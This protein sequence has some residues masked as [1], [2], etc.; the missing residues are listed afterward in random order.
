MSCSAFQLQR[1]RPGDYVDEV[2]KERDDLLREV[3]YAK[4]ELGRLTTQLQ[5]C[6]CSDSRSSRKLHHEQDES[7]PERPARKV[8]ATQLKA[9]PNANLPSDQ[10]LA[11]PP[12]SRRKLDYWTPQYHTTL[13]LLKKCSRHDYCMELRLA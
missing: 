5:S 4:V 13:F 10:I 6:R 2:T 3:D 12:L 9:G 8:R 11:N 1:D 7:A